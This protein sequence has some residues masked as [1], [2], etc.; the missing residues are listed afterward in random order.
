[1]TAGEEGLPWA[2]HFPGGISTLTCISGSRLAPGGKA[3]E[4]DKILAHNLLNTPRE[5]T[6]PS[7]PRLHAQRSVSALSGRHRTPRG[8]D[9][10]YNTEQRLSSIR[11]QGVNSAVPPGQGQLGASVSDRAAWLGNM[12]SAVTEVMCLLSPSSGTLWSWDKL[13]GKSNRTFSQTS[14]TQ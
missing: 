10:H 6:V 9:S 1:M 14:V 11:N 12:A 8:C 2:R 7:A 3:G 13:C 4:G 5:A